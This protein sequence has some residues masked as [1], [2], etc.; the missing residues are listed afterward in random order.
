MSE[1]SG[2]TVPLCITQSVQSFSSPGY[3]R[4]NMGRR[5][6]VGVPR[7]TSAFFIGGVA[8]LLPFAGSCIGAPDIITLSQEIVRYHAIEA[9]LPVFPA[10]SG[11]TDFERRVV[12]T[13]VVNSGGGSVSS[14]KVVESSDASL[15]QATESALAQW[16]F[17]SFSATPP[18]LLSTRLVFYFTMKSGHGYVTDAAF[19]ILE[20]DRKRYEEKQR[21]SSNSGQQSR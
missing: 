1:L 4:R 17:S 7:F 3:F 9:P 14:I 19:E 8:W 18:K 12:V 21:K 11:Q 20:R 13:I 16:R 10:H 5:K 2:V 15:A 6:T